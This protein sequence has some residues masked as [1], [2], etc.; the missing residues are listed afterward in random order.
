M[1]AEP[2][3]GVDGPL[4]DV[5]DEGSGLHDPRLAVGG[6][7]P[8]QAVARGEQVVGAAL[9]GHDGIVDSDG[10]GGIGHL[11]AELTAT[12]LGLGGMTCHHAEH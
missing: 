8:L 5:L 9:V 3:H 12:G 6:C 1:A 7:G 11:T 10:V 2:G 4:G